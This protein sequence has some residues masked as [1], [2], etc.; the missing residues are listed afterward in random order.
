VYPCDP[1]GRDATG[2]DEPHAPTTKAESWWLSTRPVLFR[3]RSVRLQR[4]RSDA[5]RI[6]AEGLRRQ[7]PIG[8]D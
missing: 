2:L 7:R 5:N 4:G 3:E 8:S 6:R 1:H